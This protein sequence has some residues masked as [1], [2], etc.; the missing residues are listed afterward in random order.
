MANTFD[1][2]PAKLNEILDESRKLKSAKT[3]K[4]IF[5]IGGRGHYENPISDML[6]FF[7][8][9]NEEHGFGDQIVQCLFESISDEKKPLANSPY[10]IGREQQTQKNNRID[11]YME[12]D[13]NIV[14][15]ENKI[16]ADLINDLNDYRDYAKK[17]AGNKTVFCFVLSPYEKTEELPAGWTN[18]NYQILVGN[19]R[20]KLDILGVEDEL[21]YNLQKNKW[22]ILLREFILN[23]ESESGQEMDYEKNE[24]HNEFFEKKYRDILTIIDNFSCY[25]ASLRVYIEKVLNKDGSE[26]R[27]LVKGPMNW[28]HHMK[29]YEITRNGAWHK[30]SNIF[31]VLCPEEGRNGGVLFRVQFYVGSSDPE[32]M[33]ADTDK[34]F[35]GFI[36]K[37][38]YPHTRNE[39][40]RR[41]YGEYD[42]PKI[43][44]ALDEVKK[45]V[46]AHDCHYKQHIK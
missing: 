7:L 5:S 19:I 39:K 15:I 23:I 8:D 16:H 30:H 20:N 31:L 1:I 4:N 24:C 22:R 26:Q 41:Y 45:I 33:Q 10:R 38:K 37:E 36:S 25:Q 46:E 18:I 13:D 11:I 34:F 3:E 29:A 2:S 14:V 27:V 21:K 40:N 12:S 42:C 43:G 35:S 9:Q 17:Q 28:R 44:T 32:A 6:A